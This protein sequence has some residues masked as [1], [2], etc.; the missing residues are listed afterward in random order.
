V[1]QVSVDYDGTIV[2]LDYVASGNSQIYSRKIGIDDGFKL[3]GGGLS[4][5][6]VRNG[7]MAGTNS[8]D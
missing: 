6:T 7:K 4:T 2:I 1:K 3:M 8:G 5:V